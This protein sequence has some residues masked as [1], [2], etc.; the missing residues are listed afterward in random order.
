VYIIIGILNFRT[1][2]DEIKWH[3]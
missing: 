2:Y 1:W 3:T